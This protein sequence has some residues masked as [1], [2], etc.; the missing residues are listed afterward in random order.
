MKITHIETVR[1]SDPADVIWVRVHTD[2]GLICS[3]KEISKTQ[4]IKPEEEI[5]AILTEK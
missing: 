2:T 1:V 3:M 4:I 5:L